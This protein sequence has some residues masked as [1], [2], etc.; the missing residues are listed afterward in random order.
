MD[1]LKKV[2][3]ARKARVVATGPSITMH[4]TGAQSSAMASCSSSSAVLAGPVRKDS[5]KKQKGS[6]DSVSKIT[7]SV[8]FFGA[9]SN[10]KHQ[11]NYCKMML[12]VFPIHATPVFYYDTNCPFINY[13]ATKRV[14]PT[15]DYAVFLRCES[16]MNS[17]IR[18]SLTL[19]CC[20]DHAPHQRW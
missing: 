15:I 17:E 8:D 18:C 10:W 4:Y 19:I 5:V 11:H 20:L 3:K 12:F 9:K 2:N 6:K 14:I 1:R 7:N 16:W 13:V